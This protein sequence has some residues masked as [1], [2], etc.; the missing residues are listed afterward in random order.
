M[1]NKNTGCLWPII[2]IIIF[3]AMIGGCSNNSSS[4]SG[5]S[6]YS[7]YSSEYKTNSSY[8]KNVDDIARTYGTTS[9]HV[10]DVINAVAGN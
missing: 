5:S 9:K 3:L 8:R 7:G 6:R 1:E 10:D 2:I 4:S